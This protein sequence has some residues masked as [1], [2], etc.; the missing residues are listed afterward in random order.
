MT[1]FYTILSCIIPYKKDAG[2]KSDIL[3]TVNL[4]LFTV[5]LINNT[6]ERITIEMMQFICY[7]ATIIRLCVYPE[8]DPVII[9][10]TARQF[11]MEY[12]KAVDEIRQQNRILRVH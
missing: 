2:S 10:N 4:C 3:F 6:F 1:F 11:Q 7:P 8:T 5:V 12:V 9:L